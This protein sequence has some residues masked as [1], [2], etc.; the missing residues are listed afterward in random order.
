MSRHLIYV[1]T[2]LSMG[3]L[4]LSTMPFQF[5]AAQSINLN[6]EGY[7][8]NESKFRGNN[9]T[10]I[11]VVFHMENSTVHKHLESVTDSQG[12]FYFK[13][14][15]FDPDLTYGVSVNYGGALYGTD[16]DLSQGSP[17]PLKVTIYEPITNDDVIDV[18]LSS[19]LFADVDT[20]DM[21]ITALEI[22]NIINRSDQTYVPGEEPMNLLR[23]GLPHDSRD[24]QVDTSLLGSGFIQVDRGFALM[25]SVPPGKYEVMYTYKFPFTENQID[26]NK[27]M[28][29]G[30]ESV[31]VLIP[32]ELG[33]LYSPNLDNA[34][35]ITIGDSIYNLIKGQNISRDSKL[36]L[37]IS[38]LPEPSLKDVIN[39]RI[40][41]VR[42]EFVA[43]FA[44]FIL[45]ICVLAVAIIN[46]YKRQR[47]VSREDDS[48]INTESRSML[49][50]MVSELEKEFDEGRIDD[51]EYKTRRRMLEDRLNY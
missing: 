38:N 6:V 36:T 43:P 47:G 23:F 29:Y 45:M 32:K 5:T 10:G 13:D 25:A 34:E 22:I 11:T 51:E 12:K 3:L 1:A 14:I 27:T 19:T 26:L 37:R 33:Y 7:L 48:M 49:L 46:K 41:S 15:Y 39:N 42:F 24:L 17:K 31:R 20:K 16:I 9:V 50:Q 35:S 40:D 21:M 30:G 18:T 2:L 8:T 4:Y 44:L 28:R